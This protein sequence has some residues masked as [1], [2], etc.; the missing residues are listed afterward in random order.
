MTDRAEAEEAA[1]G[2]RMIELEVRFFTN[3]LAETG[4][5]RPKEG[6]TRGVVRVTPNDVHGIESSRARHFNSLAELPATIERVLI[7]NGITLHAVGKT[8]KYLSP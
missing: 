7:E 1:H 5:V 3:E 2:Q 8:S 4:R 6:W